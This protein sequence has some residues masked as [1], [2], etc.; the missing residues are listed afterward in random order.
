MKQIDKIYCDVRKNM[1]HQ[2]PTTYVCKLCKVNPVSTE[3]QTCKE[4]I[5]MEM[6]KNKKS[7]KW[8]K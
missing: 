7:D 1:K 2:I 3:D 8:L 6:L 5:F 4:F